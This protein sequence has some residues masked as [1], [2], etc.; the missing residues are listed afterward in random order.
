MNSVRPFLVGVL[1]ALM[2]LP[3]TV[4]AYGGLCADRAFGTYTHD[5][6]GACTGGTCVGSKTEYPAVWKCKFDESYPDRW[7]CSNDAKQYV[8]TVTPVKTVEN[9]SW[10]RWFACVGA[11]AA[12]GTC[13]V[14]AYAAGLFAGGVAGG[15]TAP[16]GPGAAVA[17]YAA[18]IAIGGGAGVACWYLCGAIGAADACCWVDC[19]L[20]EKHQ[21]F[22]NY[23]KGC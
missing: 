8:A 14:A 1:C 5:T 7:E 22:P 21:T 23:K 6:S 19:V 11:N 9:D 18:A 4:W 2:A 17:A 3:N 15:A 16:S 10:R 13:I 12:C 20:D